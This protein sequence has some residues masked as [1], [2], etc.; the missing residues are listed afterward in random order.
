MVTAVEPL[1]RGGGTYIRVVPLKDV[2]NLKGILESI[3]GCQTT[4]STS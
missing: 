4:S 3:P 2:K 1:H